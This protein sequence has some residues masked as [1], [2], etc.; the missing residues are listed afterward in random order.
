MKN[1]AIFLIFLFVHCFATASERQT[2]VL[3][4]SSIGTFEISAGKKISLH[5]LSKAFPEYRVTHEIGM[6]DSPDFHL[7]TVA[8][9]QGEA[10]ISFISYVQEQSM[11][12]AALV[13]LDE[14]L[15]LAGDVK[16]QY[17]V[18]PGDTLSS[19]LQ[20]RPKMEH[21]YGHM[22]SYLGT[23]KIW[24]LFHATTAEGIE[25]P[26]DQATKINPRIE[27]ISGPVP[28]WR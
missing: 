13:P 21:G 8:T 4:E 15:L 23:G 5:M 20:K 3:T 6:G 11:Y 2:I 24:Y 10:I 25:V 28:R 9:H 27:V 7:F 17:G 1:I 26:L 18:S 16:D 22:D 14:V 19:A 12:E